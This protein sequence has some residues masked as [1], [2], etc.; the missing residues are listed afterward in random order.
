M[1]Y[2]KNYDDK[3][4]NI[5]SLTPLKKLAFL[6]SINDKEAQTIV[7]NVEANFEGY[8]EVEEIEEI[9]YH[10]IREEIRVEYDTDDKTRSYFVATA[11]APYKKRQIE[12][13]IQDIIY[14]LKD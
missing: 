3:I 5:M 13:I 9:H 11:L 8:T 6:K 7:S 10:R 14:H 12:H 1:I 4:Y 2:L